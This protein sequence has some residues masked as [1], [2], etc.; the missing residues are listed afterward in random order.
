M[1]AAGIAT[2]VLVAVAPPLTTLTTTR[3]LVNTHVLAK[4][5]PGQCPANATQCSPTTPL[6]APA[7]V[8][9]ALLLFVVGLA[10]IPRAHGRLMRRRKQGLDL[11]PSGVPYLLLRPPR[12]LAFA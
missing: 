2:L 8:F 7:V 12:T 9:G 6:P 4:S 5:A 3:H 1:V 11:L 10:V